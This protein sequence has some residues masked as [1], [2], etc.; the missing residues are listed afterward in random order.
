MRTRPR[1]VPSS[2]EA[3]VK[4]M[5]PLRERYDRPALAAFVT[6][7]HRERNHQGLGNDLLDPFRDQ[8][9][10]VPACPQRAA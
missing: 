8:H 2:Q 6:S 4:R 1:F 7:H 5:V 3:C 9:S 10:H